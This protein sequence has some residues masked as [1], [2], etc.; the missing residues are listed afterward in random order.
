M[1]TDILA[2]L[3]EARDVL[4]GACEPDHC[5]LCQVTRIINDAFAAVEDENEE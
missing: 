4:C 1:D 5:D 3:C 2:K